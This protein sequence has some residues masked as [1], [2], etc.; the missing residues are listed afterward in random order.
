MRYSLAPLSSSAVEW[1][2]SGG[3]LATAVCVHA[4]HAHTFCCILFAC[5]SLVGCVLMCADKMNYVWRSVMRY[6]ACCPF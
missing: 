2:I 3:R 1:L 4:T 6:R 5:D